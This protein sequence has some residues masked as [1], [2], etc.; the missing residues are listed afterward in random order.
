MSD[1]LRSGSVLEEHWV[2]GCELIQHVQYGNYD[3][4]RA[5]ESAVIYCSGWL[6]RRT[7][8]DGGEGTYLQGMA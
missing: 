5:S 2:R 8:P 7:I 6:D 1:L 3:I 4:E